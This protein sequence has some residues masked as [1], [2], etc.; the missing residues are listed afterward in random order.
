MSNI[1]QNE[2]N[3]MFNKINYNST[4]LLV[5]TLRNIFYNTTDFLDTMV[6]LSNFVA[7]DV[8]IHKSIKFVGIVNNGLNSLLKL[9]MAAF[10]N[11]IRNQSVKKNDEIIEE[12]YEF[13]NLKIITNMSYSAPL[14]ITLFPESINILVFL[15]VLNEKNENVKYWHLNDK[16]ICSY[17][18]FIEFIY[19]ISKKYKY[20]VELY[21]IL[22]Q[23]LNLE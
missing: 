8:N 19:Y 15:K 2:I 16:M 13:K 22:K 23:Y 4:I 20:K 6:F 21:K 18:E 11:S 12:I 3:V 5:K 17:S 10:S 14:H 7:P 1:D 9:H